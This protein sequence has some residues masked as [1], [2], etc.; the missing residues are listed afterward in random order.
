MSLWGQVTCANNPNIYFE[1]FEALKSHLAARPAFLEYL[2][3]LIVP[4]K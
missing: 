1:Q 2:E 3:T 4:V